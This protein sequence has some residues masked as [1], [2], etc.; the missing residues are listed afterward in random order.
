VLPRKSARLDR[1]NTHGWNHHASLLSI[2]DPERG[3][4][5]D[6]PVAN[7]THRN[8]SRPVGPQGVGEGP[9]QGTPFAAVAGEALAGAPDRAEHAEALRAPGG[10]EV[11]APADRVQAEA[12]EAVQ[13]AGGLGAQAV[14]FTTSSKSA[15]AISE[16]MSTGLAS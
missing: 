5:Q 4:R 1:A 3:D 10:D 9:E 7:R 13:G 16:M 6:A 12:L 8:G 11:V 15:D 14:Q 2:I